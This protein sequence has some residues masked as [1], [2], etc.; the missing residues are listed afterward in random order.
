MNQFS[1]RPG[2]VGLVED[3]HN[4]N[5]SLAQFVE[6]LF[7]EFVPLPGGGDDD[8]HVGAVE[9][10]PRPLDAELAQGPGVVDPRR[11]DEQ[12]RPDGEQFH[13]LFDRV[14]RGA[15]HLRDDRHLLPRQ[16][17]QERGLSGVAA[18]EES[19]VQAEGFWRWTHGDIHSHREKPNRVAAGLARR[20]G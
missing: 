19:D 7:L 15:G 16:G 14:S 9:D 17:I 3:D 2:Q 1:D 20:W 4:R 13:W 11:V 12:H 18:A 10:L 5:V 8:A 6:E